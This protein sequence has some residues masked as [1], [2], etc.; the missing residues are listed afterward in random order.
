MGDDS[1][2]L[3]V[4]HP[5]RNQVLDEKADSSQSSPAVLVSA[6]LAG[7]IRWLP[8]QE[9]QCN[10]VQAMCRARVAHQLLMAECFAPLS[11]KYVGQRNFALGTLYKYEK[12]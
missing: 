4:P 7:S 9:L 1:G 8:I 12:C 3:G 10:S 5:T 11:S 6:A 2:S